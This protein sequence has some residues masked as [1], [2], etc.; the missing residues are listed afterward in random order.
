MTNLDLQ[1]HVAA[2]VG[3][4][5]KGIEWFEFGPEDLFPSK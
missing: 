1:L 4:G 3:S 2:V 5:A